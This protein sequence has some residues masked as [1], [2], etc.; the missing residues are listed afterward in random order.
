MITGMD[1]GFIHRYNARPPGGRSVAE[2]HLPDGI[3]T[4][5]YEPETPVQLRLSM[6]S[7]R[8]S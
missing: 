8:F 3:A 5:N 2:V 4:N 7:A 6:D 1:G